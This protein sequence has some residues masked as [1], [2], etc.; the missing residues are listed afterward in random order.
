MRKTF[1]GMLVVAGICFVQAP[2][3]LAQAA[4]TQ[5]APAAS[6]D[7]SRYVGTGYQ[8]VSRRYPL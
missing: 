4:S 6:T 2:R 1:L 5:K 3:S 8:V 7:N